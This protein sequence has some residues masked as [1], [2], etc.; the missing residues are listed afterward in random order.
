MTINYRVLT[1]FAWMSQASYR[2]LTGL[3]RGDP[4]LSTFL[5]D[6]R[7]FA[8]DNRFATRQAVAFTNVTAG[9]AFQHQQANDG[10][11]FS[12]T[13]F[14]SNA[15]GQY[16]IAVRGTEPL[17]QFGVDLFSADVSIAFSGTARSQVFAAYRYYKKLID[18][19]GPVD[20]TDTEV[21]QL[22]Q[23]YFAKYENV[24]ITQLRGRQDFQ[25]DV[26]D[27]RLVL[28]NDQGLGVIPAGSAINF[29]GHS[30]GGDG[31]AFLA[32]MTSCQRRPM[33]AHC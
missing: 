6:N 32:E 22:V 1:D 5:T 26:R 12:A 28:A 31:L 30:L 3:T 17:E 7:A 8:Q 9:Y 24:P 11:G 14:S 27:L 2:D 23:I 20:Y 16:T 10:N 18:T 4:R 15:S 13:V 19:G 33:W 21:E 29:A 25:I